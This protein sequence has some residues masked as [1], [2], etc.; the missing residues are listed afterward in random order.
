MFGETTMFHV[1]IWNNPTETTLLIRGCLGLLDVAGIYVIF[2]LVR[3]CPAMLELMHV[4]YRVLSLACSTKDFA[5]ML[6]PEFSVCSTIWP[7]AI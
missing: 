6:T 4:M 5:G 7:M 2:P 1:K 3:C